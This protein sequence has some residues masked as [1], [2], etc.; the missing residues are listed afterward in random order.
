MKNYQRDFFDFSLQVKAL[1]F[2]EFTLKSGRISP[3]FF[4]T[5]T[6]SS[7]STLS[8]L[9][10]FY[11]QRIVDS[12]L[13]FDM[14]YGPAYKGIPLVTTAAVALSRDFDRDVEI[15]FNRKETKDHGEGGVVVGAPLQGNVLIIDDVI[16]AGLSVGE[17]IDIIKQAGAQP[18]GV[19]IALDRQERI[20]GG[21]LSSIEAVKQR[22]GLPVFSIAT[23]EDLITYL[24]E[25]ES[26][27]ENLEAIRE[28]YNLYAARE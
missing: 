23:L 15:A 13:D 16:T 18:V 7:G 5:G 19:M 22:Y 3:Y 11:A 20:Q 27:S 4:N 1:T 14:L 8:R 2:G 17:S 12:K 28:Y 10:Y 6:F 21:D 9:G 25:S 24:G 26:H